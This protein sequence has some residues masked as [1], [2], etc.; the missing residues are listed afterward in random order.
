MTRNGGN[1][2]RSSG[3]TSVRTITQAVRHFAWGG[4]ENGNQLVPQA[5]ADVVSQNLLVSTSRKKI[6]WCN[7]ARC[8]NF[9]GPSQ[10]LGRF[11]GLGQAPARAWAGASPPPPRPPPPPAFLGCKRERKRVFT[12]SVTETIQHA[13]Q[14]RQTLF[15]LL[16]KTLTRRTAREPNCHVKST[17]IS[18][19]GTQLSRSC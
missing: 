16:H 6:S 17:V 14:G 1:R 13:P 9:K 7:K 2:R 8:V 15:E 4:R 3:A 11:Q 19:D 5:E 12:L 18:C 10:G